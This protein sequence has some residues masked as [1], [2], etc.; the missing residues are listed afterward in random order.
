MIFRQ[1]WQ[2][3]HATALRVKDFVF[4]RKAL[5][6]NRGKQV[7]WVWI[8]YQCIKGSLTTAFIWVP[9]IWYW[10]DKQ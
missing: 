8:T 7:F 1:W 4:T 3:M 5:L 6:K 9:L 10:L 2:Q